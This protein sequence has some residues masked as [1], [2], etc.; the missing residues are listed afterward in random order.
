MEKQKKYYWLK[1]DKDFFKRHDIRIIEAMS[2]GKDYVLFYLKLLVESISHNGLLRFS[3]TVPYNESMLS[4]ITNT[5]IDI[6]R[7]AIKAFIQLR[8]IEILDD[9]TIFMV[10]VENMTGSE[11]KWAGKKREY[12]DKKGHN[13][14]NVL[15][16]V[17]NVRQEIEI[18]IEIE[19]EK[20]KEIVV[21]AGP[22]ALLS[23]FCPDSFEMNCVN[24]LVES[25]LE[26]YPKAKVP[27]TDE[28]KSKWAADIEKIK[29]LDGRTEEEIWETLQFAIGS[30]F[31]QTNIRSAKKFREKYETLYLQHKQAE[32]KNGGSQRERSE[33]IPLTTKD[34]RVLE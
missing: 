27:D 30:S 24:A 5:N 8:M 7:S 2:N 19:K 17:D 13:A 4:T 29:R 25:C 9:E 34:G 12:R 32:E 26:S 20:E 21:P 22:T 28:K 33:S 23:Q 16:K 6:V 14:D 1:L 11:T 15:T 10:E 3:D 31:W 18:E